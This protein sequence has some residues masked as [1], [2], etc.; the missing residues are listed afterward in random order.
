[1][2]FLFLPWEPVDLKIAS[3]TQGGGGAFSLWVIWEFWGFIPS[4]LKWFGICN[5]DDE[6][7]RIFS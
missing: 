6:D 7:P 3:S 4:F 2:D 1:M 5:D